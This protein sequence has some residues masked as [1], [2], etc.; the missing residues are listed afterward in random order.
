MCDPLRTCHAHV[1]ATYMDAGCIAQ[2]CGAAALTLHTRY[3]E[4]LYAPPSH[5]QH[6]AALRAAVDVPIIG[7]GDILQGCDALRM[8]AD[9]GADGFMVGRACLGRPWVRA[10]SSAVQPLRCRVPPD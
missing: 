4:Q 5:W 6:I 7:N 8:R 3:A 2:D 1:Q 10:T 9:T